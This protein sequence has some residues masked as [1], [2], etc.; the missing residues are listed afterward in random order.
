MHE[1]NLLP[2]REI[3]EHKQQKKTIAKVTMLLIS[4][5]IALGFWQITI[6]RKLNKQSHDYQLLQAESAS[7]KTMNLR[8]EKT[9]SQ[10]IT[11]IN[12]NHQFT[13]LKT[14][15][16]LLNDTLQ[17]L[18]ANIP[19]NCRLDFLQINDKEILIRGDAA[20]FP[21]V[22]TFL[23]NLKITLSNQDVS[24]ETIKQTT[25]SVSFAFIIKIKNN[26]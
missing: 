25:V 22:V 20:N 17:Q 7:I 11:N 16:R 13:T 4:S 21:S 9:R 5:I 23:K 6:Q 26:D 8:L 1:I 15:Q 24:I 3:N 12:A 2:W 19:D 18:S 10:Q 14:K